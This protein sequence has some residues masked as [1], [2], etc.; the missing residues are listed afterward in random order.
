MG[1]LIR[2]AASYSRVR[3][4]IPEAPISGPPFTNLRTLILNDT[5]LTWPQARVGTLHTSDAPL[6][7]SEQ[8]RRLLC[9]H[10][11]SAGC[12]LCCP[13]WKSCT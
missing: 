4:S 7:L 9:L 3:L 12:N 2:C 8:P 1:E 13:H 10:S 6:P 5:H 11:R